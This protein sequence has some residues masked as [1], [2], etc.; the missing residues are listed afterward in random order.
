LLGPPLARAR[1]QRRARG[2]RA[3]AHSEARAEG[4]RD[5]AEEIAAAGA[6]AVAAEGS[7]EIG[8]HPLAAG[9]AERVDALHGKAGQILH[10]VS[11]S[12]RKLEIAEPPGG[13]SPR[14]TP[15]RKKAALE[16]SRQ[17]FSSGT[18]GNSANDGADCGARGLWCQEKR[19]QDIVVRLRGG[20]P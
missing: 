10:V 7:G 16:R 18:R 17:T 14:V 4:R 9:I 20:K 19:L 11:L 5:V 1:A 6:V 2:E 3:G 12:G 15:N 8:A 13:R